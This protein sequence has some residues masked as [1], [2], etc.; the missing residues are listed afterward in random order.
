MA[1][2][3]VS[4]AE[5][6][7]KASLLYDPKVRSIFF[8]VVLLLALIFGVWWIVD[9]TIENLRRSNISTGFGFLRGRAGFDIS[10]S[11]IQYSSDSTY[12]RAILVGFWNTVHRG[13]RRHHH[14]DDSRLYHRRGEAVAELAVA[15]NRD[16]LR[17]NL[18]QHSAAARHFLLVPGRAV[19]VC[20]RRAT[21]SSC[22]SVPI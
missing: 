19:G 3:H 15:E 14:G 10:D 13:G 21:A 12:G 6:P 1:M 9:N 11:L 16:G 7:A 8:Q 18:S 2:Q 20:R 5:E 17:R 22:R 4:R